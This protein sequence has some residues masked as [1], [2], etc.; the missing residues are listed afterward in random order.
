MAKKQTA[1]TEILASLGSVLVAYSGGADSTLLLWAALQALGPERVLAVTVHSALVPALELQQAT[2]TARQL[3]ARHRVIRVDVLGNPDIAANP[4]DRCYYCKRAIFSQL[5]EIARAEGLAALVHG[6]NVD[7]AGDVRP[8][9]RA[10]DELGARAPLLE[11]DLTKADVRALSRQ[12]GLPTW[13]LPSMACLASRVPYGT[14]LTAETLER[15]EA[16]ESFLRDRFHLRQLRVRDH[17]PVA[18]IEATAEDVARLAAPDARLEI[19]SRL[20]ELGYRHVTLDLEG[21]RSGSMNDA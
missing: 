9:Q 4:R 13:D 7:D 21:F 15:I 5:Q 6:V 19:V 3:G 20:R 14:P 2:E 1:L 16:A 18:R 10:A 8:G 17:W 12:V 11:A